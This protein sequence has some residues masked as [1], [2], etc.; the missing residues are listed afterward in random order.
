MNKA[1][2]NFLGWSEIILAIV[3]ALNQGLNWSGSLQYLWA[4]LLVIAGIWTFAAKA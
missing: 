4:V 2:K 3:I 1:T